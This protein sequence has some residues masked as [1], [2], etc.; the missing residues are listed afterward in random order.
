MEKKQ[1]Q[2]QELPSLKGIDCAMDA[3]HLRITDSPLHQR[4]I[5][6]VQILQDR[7]YSTWLT[8]FRKA[9]RHMGI[10][11]PVQSAQGYT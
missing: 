5:V 8:P 1:P 3:V 2:V 11:I 10:H 4:Q 9:F 6:I 7:L